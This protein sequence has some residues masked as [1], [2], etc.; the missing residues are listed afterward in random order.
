MDITSEAPPLVKDFL[1]YEATIKNRSKQTVTEYF[2][3]LRIFFRFMKRF[4]KLVPEDIPFD[5][6]PFNDIDLDFI[7]RIS[8][9][10]IYE[11]LFFLTNERGNSAVTRSRKISSLRTFYKYLSSKRNLISEN[12]TLNLETPKKKKALPKYL[13]LEQS[14]ELLKSVDGEFKERDFCIITLFLNCGLRLSELVGINISRIDFSAHTL[15]VLG[16][17]N[18]ERLVFL[19][20]AC[21]ASIT[22]YLSVRPN[23]AVK[24]KD[25]LFLSKRKQRISN[26]TVQWIINRQ[27][28]ASGLDGKGFSAHKLRHTAATLMYQSGKVDVRVLKDLLG[29]ENLATTEIYTHL[30]KSQLEEATNANPLSTIKLDKNN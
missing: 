22:D 30:A 27:L 4:Y 5:E 6:I 18:K 7:K 12:P 2:I 13:S 24:D 14:V 16:K 29:H 21:M 20:D 8:F 1:H 25:A 11:Y 15:I 3:D 26:K 10:D 28:S 19:N 17:G 9:S 23:D